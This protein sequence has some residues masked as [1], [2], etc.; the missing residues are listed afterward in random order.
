MA[1]FMLRRGLT[2]KKVCHIGMLSLTAI[3]IGPFSTSEE[4]HAEIINDEDDNSN[5]L[6]AKP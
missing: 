3:D 1:K 6:M 5:K 2:E 4:A